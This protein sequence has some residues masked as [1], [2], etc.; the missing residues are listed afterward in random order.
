VIKLAQPGTFSD[1]LTEILRNG[2][3]ALLA[4]AVEAEIAGFLGDHADKLTADGRTRLVRHGHD[5]VGAP[6]ASREQFERK[7][8]P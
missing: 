6:W 7:T 3:R 1:P 5:A 2:A 8:D 4:H